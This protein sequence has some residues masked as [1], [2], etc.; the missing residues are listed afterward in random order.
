M[1][2]RWTAFA[3]LVV[4]FVFAAMLA[5][6]P[7]FPHYFAPVAALVFFLVIQSARHFR[8]WLWRLRQSRALRLRPACIVLLPLIVLV[9]MY[10]VQGEPPPG[11]GFTRAALLNELKEKGGRHLVIVSYEASHNA[12]H[13]WVYNDADLDSSPII[14]ARDMGPQSNRALIDAYRDRQVWWL[15]ADVRPA[16][17][18][19]YPEKTSAEDR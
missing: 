5:P 13:E 19:P 4:G 10:R 1:R 9:W 7:L 18:E 16:R 14:W 8:L 3:L 11:W 12:N 2:Q 15:R 6:P 17:L